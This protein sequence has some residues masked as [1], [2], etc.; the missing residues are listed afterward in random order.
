MDDKEFFRMV[1]AELQEQTDRGVAIIGGSYVENALEAYMRSVWRN[2]SEGSD[3]VKILPEIFNFS[4]PVGAF[5]AKIRIAFISRLIGR[6]A[7]KDL[8]TVKDIRNDFAHKIVWDSMSA[9]H[10]P[11]R[12]STASVGARCKNLELW[13]PLLAGL[14]AGSHIHGFQ[15]DTDDPR[16]RYIAACTQWSLL[17]NLCL[18]TSNEL[19]K[20]RLLA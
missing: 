4:G 16:S 20:K 11:L 7:Y 14:Q 1:F 18:N 13:P 6:K 3:E 12:F 15:V 8:N 2:E 17:L 10:E 9:S 19:W 5:S